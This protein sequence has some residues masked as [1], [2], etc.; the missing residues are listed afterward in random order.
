MPP[1][2]RQNTKSILNVASTISQRQLL[3]PILLSRAIVSSL[4][5]SSLLHYPLSSVLT[6]ADIEVITTVHKNYALPLSLKNYE[7][8]STD[9]NTYIRILDKVRSIDLTTADDSLILLVNIVEDTLQGALNLATL[10]MHNMYDELK[11]SNLKR[12]E[13]DILS[14]KNQKKTI[15]DTDGQYKLERTFFLSPLYSNYVY[16][17]GMPKFGVGFDPDKVLFVEKLLSMLA[18]SNNDLAAILNPTDPNMFQN[19]PT[20][21]ASDNLLPALSSV[22]PINPND[23]IALPTNVGSDPTVFSDLGF[24][25]DPSSNNSSWNNAIKVQGGN[26]TIMNEVLPAP[27]YTSAVD[28]SFVMNEGQYVGNVMPNVAFIPGAKDINVSSSGAASHEAPVGPV[29]GPSQEETKFLDAKMQ[30]SKPIDVSSTGQMTLKQLQSKN[31]YV[32]WSDLE[33]HVISSITEKRTTMD[34]TKLKPNT[35]LFY[36]NIKDK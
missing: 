28:P 18:T 11:L 16:L 33:S 30:P 12:E 32:K 24:L 20:V 8:I 19:D 15:T 1:K 21:D 14:K 22:D 31:K 26:Y 9:Y 3:N 17:Y 10:Y 6:D 4:S 7:A 23:I 13:E 27:V 34:K 2:R 35:K 25:S 29:P 5:T 36:E